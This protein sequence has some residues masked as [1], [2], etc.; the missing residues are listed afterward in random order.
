MDNTHRIHV[1][2]IYLHLAHFY[3]FPEVYI[4]VPWILL[5]DNKTILLKLDHFAR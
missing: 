3:G 4:L 5:D 2:Y 1:W